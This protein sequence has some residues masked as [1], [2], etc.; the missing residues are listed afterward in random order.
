MGLGTAAFS[1]LDA[2]L[3]RDLPVRD[4]KSLVWVAVRDRQQ[5][6]EEMSWIEYERTAQR[7][8]SFSALL[9]QSRHSPKVRLADRDDYPI[10]AGVSDNFFDLLGVR[11]ARGEV[12]HGGAG[13]TETALISDRYW[14]SAFGGDP[15]IVGRTLGLG[16]SS[17]TMLGVLPA[18]FGGTIRGLAVDIFVPQQTFFDTLRMGSA[19]DPKNS[20]FEVLGRLREG[21]T[22]EQARREVD[23]VLREVDSQGISPEPGRTAIIEPFTESGVAGK[24]H[25]HGIFPAMV[26]LMLVIAGMNIASLRLVDNEVRRRD[27]G[28]RLALG[29]R[30]LALTREH[31]LET[32]IVALSGSALGIVLATWI[33]DF[34]PSLL[35][36]G[37]R[38]T[39]YA[40]RMDWRT[41]GF[42]G[43]SL[44]LV[45]ALGSLIPL[46]DAWKHGLVAALQARTNRRSSRWLAVLVIGQMAFV[47]AVACSASLLWRSLENVAAIRPAMDPDR[48]MLLV[49]AWWEIKVPFASRAEA[50]AEQLSGIP[51]V[52]QV[53]YARRA[54]LSGSGGGAAVDVE[55]PTKGQF[56]YRLNQVSPSY[57]AT[58]G[59][60]ILKGRGFSRA[61]SSDSVP[62]V[63][64][65]ETFA[66]R[67]Y[68]GS[69]AIGAW[70]RA[71]G[72]DR[73]I[74]GVVEDGPTIHL[75]E[76][77]APYL[78]FPFAQNPTD[79]LT[80]FIACSKDAGAMADA[81]RKTLRGAD[82][83]LTLGSITTFQQHMNRARAGER[84]AAGI[85]GVLCGVGLLLA[86]A[87]LFGVTFHSV[88]R[89]TKEF[90][91][92]LALG[93]TAGNLRRQVLR[94]AAWKAALAL[95][96]GWLLAWSSRRI[97][98]KYLFGV[99][100]MDAWVPA[101]A[102]IVVL[103]VAILATLHPA[104]RAAGV[105]A[106]EALRHE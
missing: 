96:A 85:A 69:D 17:V 95:P 3:F 59:A 31:V 52:Q 64:V 68:E 2:Y 89:R 46:S 32:L 19:M 71:G 72:K 51:G 103:L 29:A 4:P 100:A 7:A 60:R 57:F 80:F 56:S 73:Q 14:R 74:V 1:I 79:Y 43:A 40:I 45:A 12:F 91:V 30:R 99:T 8:R 70:I 104:H 50:L 63:M 18:G 102:S 22:I 86:A 67:F 11:A 13:H 47:T 88:S 106:M 20:D 21:V 62:V 101:V 97:L 44:V 37:E 87:G 5:R 54:M 49:R 35:Y 39:D 10:T 48:R 77:S 81:V 36:A 27:T 25:E 58:T 61:D 15:G 42:S 26:L 98:E 16:R 41:L 90:G 78:Y 28:I 66:R 93:A 65:N 6:L 9:A 53:T 84:L 92:R 34:A 105:D 83:A 55:V 94:E 33:I 24:L 23:A 38:Y 76:Q 82:S 75:K